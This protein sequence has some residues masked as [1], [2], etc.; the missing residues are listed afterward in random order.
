MRNYRRRYAKLNTLKQQYLRSQL[1]E[2]KSN[3]MATPPN[4]LRNALQSVTNRIRETK[5]WNHTLGA[6]DKLAWE[7]W[8]WSVVD[9]INDDCNRNIYASPEQQ[10]NTLKIKVIQR[11]DD[12]YSWNRTLKEGDH[13][14]FYAWIWTVLDALKQYARDGIR[15]YETS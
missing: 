11:I 1:D 14:T 6:G 8:M 10:I 3:S 7:A 12:T 2:Q 4:H 9:D 13:L 15:E 5:R